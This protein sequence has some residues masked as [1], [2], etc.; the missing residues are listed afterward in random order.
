MEEVKGKAEGTV[1]VA[2]GVG[3]APTPVDWYSGDTVASVLERAKIE[4]KSGQTATLGRRR[5][6]HPEKTK[7]KAGDTIVIAGKISNGQ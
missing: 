2:N 3:N 1:N 7:V 5:V 4:I 6:K